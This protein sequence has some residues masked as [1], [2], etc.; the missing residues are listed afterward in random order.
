MLYIVTARLAS[1]FNLMFN[2]GDSQRGFVPISKQ[3]SIVSKSFKV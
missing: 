1:C 2:S 3:K